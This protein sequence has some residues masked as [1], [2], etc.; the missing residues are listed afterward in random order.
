MMRDSTICKEYRE[1]KNKKEQI[2]ILADLN[3]CTTKLIKEILV[4][5]GEIL[6]LEKVKKNSVTKEE[7]AAGQNLP[8]V[9]IKALCNR[10]DQLD[11]DIHSIEKEY[12]EI[13]EFIKGYKEVEA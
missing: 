9:V 12:K 7:L 4:E 1:A 2:K 8:S 6:P 13:S 10:L 5:G 3:L 11:S